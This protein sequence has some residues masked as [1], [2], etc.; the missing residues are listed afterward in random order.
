MFGTKNKRII[1]NIPPR[2]NA[3]YWE[4]GNP[5]NET[6]KVL[7]EAKLTEWKMTEVIAKAH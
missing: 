3:G 6:V 7:K 2:S 5:R 4:E 1:P